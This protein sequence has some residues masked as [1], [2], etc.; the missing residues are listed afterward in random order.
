VKL[1]LLIPFYFVRNPSRAASESVRKSMAYKL[2]DRIKQKRIYL[3]SSSSESDSSFSDPDYSRTRPRR[4]L[5]QQNSTDVEMVEVLEKSCRRRRSKRAPYSFA[6]KTAAGR[7]PKK[8]RTIL[9]WLIDM[10]IVEENVEVWYMDETRER[11][12]VKGMITRAG[13]FCHCCKKEISVWEFENHAESDLKR[14]Y[15]NIFL[16]RKRVSLLECQL[17]GS[18]HYGFNKIEPRENAVD[19]NDDACMICADGGDLICCDKCPSTFHTDCMHMEAR[20]QFLFSPF[21]FFFFSFS[22]Y[23]FFFFFFFFSFFFFFYKKS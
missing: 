7:Q 1:R 4:Q 8:K 18:K 2:R 23:F 6:N 15:A 14:P 17:M 11:I 9:S 16:A 12:L 13:I 3:S 19:K 10:E 22:V 21:F 20:F 5:T